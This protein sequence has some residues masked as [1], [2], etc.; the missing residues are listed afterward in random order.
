[1]RRRGDDYQWRPNDNSS[2]TNLR[3]DLEAEHW[4][5]AYKN[6]SAKTTVS[7]GKAL[8]FVGLILSL[9]FISLLFIVLVIRE[10]VLYIIGRRKSKKVRKERLREKTLAD[11]PEGTLFYR[12]PPEEMHRIHNLCKA[13]RDI[14]ELNTTI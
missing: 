3:Y 7:F 4:L 12:T 1:M 14:K 6:A 9:F 10:G 8:G 11:F 13:N 2:R 5:T